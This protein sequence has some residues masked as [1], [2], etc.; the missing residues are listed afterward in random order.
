MTGLLGAF[1][2]ELMLVTYRAVTQGGTKVGT[3]SPLAAPLPSTFVSP[4]IVYGA[5]G[6]LP[7]S[8]AP[9]PS[10]VGWGFVVATFLNLYNPGGANAVAQANA[11]LGQGL[12]ATPNISPAGK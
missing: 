10:L 5:L 8:L 7:R 12:S 9:L 4:V 2:A 6:L 1:V 11:S 3:T